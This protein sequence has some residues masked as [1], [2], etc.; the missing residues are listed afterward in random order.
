MLRDLAFKLH[1]FLTALL[2]GDLLAINTLSPVGA[3]P[4]KNRAQD[5][6]TITL[7]T[8]KP[9]LLTDTLTPSP[10]PTPTDT[11]TPT[12][13]PTS[14]FTPTLTFT[15]THT[16]TAPGHIAISEFRTNGPYG[17][18]DEFVELYNPTGAAVNLSSWQIRKS[19]AC[20]AAVLAPLVT[21]YYGVILQPGQHYLLAAVYP[22]SS[23]SSEDQIFTPGIDD[24]GGLALVN[25]GGSI[26]DQVGMCDGTYYHE[27]NTLVA[28]SGSSDQ[29][30]ERKPGGETA[31]YDTKDNA[32]DF[33]LISPSTP[34]NHLS[35]AVRC[36]GVKLASATPTP[37]RTAT[38][39]PTR[40][41]TAIPQQIVLNEF[42]P[43]PHSDWNGDGKANV[44]D[45]YIEIINLSTLAIN[46]KN[47]R[48]DTG[49]DS[50]TTYTL[51]DMTLQP[52]QI[53][54][55]FRTLTGLAL[56][57]G[58][59]TVRLLKPSGFIADAYTYP[60]VERADRA[61]C[62]QPDGNGEW[63]F[64]CLPSPGR[65]NIFLNA[66]QQPGTQ[67][68]N[69]SVCLLENTIPK[70]ITLAECGNLGSGMATNTGE[71]LFWLESRWKWDVFVE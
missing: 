57:D 53:A 1:L 30:Y 42:L 46:V 47:W 15:P 32:S 2:V 21:I 14:T 69:L 5:G 51:P 61:W 8:D 44:G 24:N 3:A 28:L 52:R 49:T 71:M 18:Y 31:C 22:Y 39:T 59:G 70:S 54:K 25:S 55:F 66:S 56:S 45:E 48:L 6:G 33:T 43:R 37:T 38:R 50:N 11:K 35:P 7:P 58:G 29:S 4:E 12:D 10:T 36:N 17:A 67:T 64:V 23:I 13:T 41:P 19:A 40:A 65:P 62:R 34:L 9:V 60:V 27:G 68:G 26:I 16:P 63:G 20:G